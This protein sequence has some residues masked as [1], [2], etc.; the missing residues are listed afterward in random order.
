MAVASQSELFTS[1]V[2]VDAKN[3][4]SNYKNWNSFYLK[5][6]S[7]LVK[8]GFSMEKVNKKNI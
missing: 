2:W 4:S 1:T 6:N 8:D 7:T 3:L 5:S